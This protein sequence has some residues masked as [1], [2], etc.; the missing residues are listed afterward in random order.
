MPAPR[1][2]LALAILSLTSC[3][4]DGPATIDSRA[5]PAPPS[6]HVGRVLDPTPLVDRLFVARAGAGTIVLLD[7]ETGDERARTETAGYGGLVDLTFDPASGA[8]FSYEENE[9]GEGA[10][11]ARFPIHFGADAPSFGSRERLAWV[12]GVA[13]LAATSAGLLEVEDDL[14]QRWSLSREGA[15]PLTSVSCPRPASLVGVAANGEV[16]LVGLSS[17]YPA[18]DPVERLEVVAG[19]AGLGTCATTPLASPPSSARLARLDD[20]TE[21]VVG[22]RAGRVQIERLEGGVGAPLGSTDLDATTVEAAGTLESSPDVLVVLTTAPS[23]LAVVRVDRTATGLSLGARAQVS[24]PPVRREQQF[25]SRELAVMGRRVLV[26]TEGGL[27]AFDV[28]GGE[29]GLD[30][31]PAPFASAADARGPV[32]SLPG[33]PRSP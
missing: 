16:H 23:S 30:L 5:R 6:S 9:D 13:R 32:L 18:E 15:G 2:A 14:G 26:A 4:S 12:A 31:E 1:I 20:G 11:L 29:G 21:L 7:A 24:L 25:F 10:E 33:R 19:A 17:P 27:L 3:R 22:V 28:V 8:L